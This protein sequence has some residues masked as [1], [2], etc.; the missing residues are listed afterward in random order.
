VVGRT[1]TIIAGDDEAE[2][3]VLGLLQM[4]KTGQADTEEAQRL[5]DY[6]FPPLRP[7]DPPLKGR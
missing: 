7:K 5:R 1:L 6:L 2:E 4:H 3:A